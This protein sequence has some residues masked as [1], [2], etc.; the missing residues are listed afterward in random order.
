VALRAV[1][2]A[3]PDE[4]LTWVDHLEEL[5]SRLFVVG[6]ALAVAFGLC[7]WQS[8]LVLRVIN[9][10]LTV[11]TEKQVRAGRGPLG[12]TALDQAALKDLASSTAALADTLASPKSGLPPQ[13]RNDLF[14]QA[15]QIAA[16]VRRLP[17][18]PQG[19]KPITLGVGEPFTATLTVALYVAIPLALPVILFELYGFVI[20]AFTPQEK[21]IALPLMYAAPI[22][23]IAGLLFGYFVV[24][25]AAIDFL[26]NYNSSQ[27]NVMVQANQ[28]YR[29]AAT[30][31]IAVGLSFELPV[32]VVGLVAAEVV[33]AGWLAKRR[34]WAIV[35]CALIAAVLPGE[36]VTMVLEG[37]PLY[38]LF[39]LSVLCARLIERRRRRRALALE[40]SGP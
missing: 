36:A 18:Q 39:E 23:F 11:Q 17:A 14:A 1:K 32:A 24:L 35:I 31:L 2:I 29:F 37:I 6:L 33:S 4:Q 15:Q 9:H 3:S 27:F 16:S 26:Q 13:L 10:P 25:P 8:G 21:R 19:D 22:L 30:T 34:R 40:A 38:L 5:R 20:P 28:Y 7:L 12:Q